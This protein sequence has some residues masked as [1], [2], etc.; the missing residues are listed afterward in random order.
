M[1]NKVKELDLGEKD[2]TINAGTKPSW[3]DPQFAPNVLN[4]DNMNVSEP[5]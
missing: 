1:Q 4:L 3:I 2:A 5:K